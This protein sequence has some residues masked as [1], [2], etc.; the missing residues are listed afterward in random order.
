MTVEN[1][2]PP[3]NTNGD[4][5]TVTFGFNFKIQREAFLKVTQTIVAT[6]EETD[7]AIVSSTGIGDPAGGT[8]TVGAAPP[9]GS[10]VSVDSNVD[11]EQAV[12]LDG[13]DIYPPTVEEMIDAVVI[14]NQGQETKINRSIRV[15]VSDAVVP[16]LPA[17]AQRADKIL[18]FTADGSDFLMVEGAAASQA[19]VDQAETQADRAVA[20]ATYPYTS[21]EQKTGAFMPGT[22]ES[23]TLFTYNSVSDAAATLPALSGLAAGYNIGACRTAGSGDVTFTADDGALI[24]GQSSIVLG[25]DYL[26]LDFTINEA[27]DEWVAV[28]KAVVGVPIGTG[29]GDIVAIGSDGKLPEIDGSRLT[30]VKDS[31]A[32]DTALTAY[33]KAEIIAG[34]PGGTYGK[35]ISDNFLT[36][37]LAVST[38]ATYDADGDYYHNPGE[39]EEDGGHADSSYT[40]TGY[41]LVD[42]TWAVNNSETVTKVKIK[43][44]SAGAVKAKLLLENS[45]TDLDILYEETFSHSGG[46]WQTFTLTTPQDIPASG[47]YRIG[48]YSA[49]APGNV[50]AS[51]ARA[52]ISSDSNDATTFTADTGGIWQAG[53]FYQSD[54]LN[55]ILQSAAVTL[56]DADPSDI[57]AL[58]RVEDIDAV[59]D[60]TDR[61][62]SFSIDNGAT[63]STATITALGAYGVEDAMI[64]TE[65]D[66]SG[67]TGDQFVVKLVTANNKAQRIKQYVAIPEY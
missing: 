22:D 16:S 19:Y 11:F 13:N 42:R 40:F 52:Y 3:T 41:T 2:L 55:I 47:T 63:F 67:Q 7:L 53:V 8:V 21:G 4:G 32:R 45:S 10:I 25:S 12:E 37:T 18:G 50:G 27:G 49:G 65:A 59:V 38:N 15:P 14:Q 66:V 29:A 9:S 30:N 31:A 43:Q 54:P 36:D 26:C 64:K 61:M 28:D 5:T 46:G 23:L 20:A 56:E 1:Q 62:I 44:E 24:N 6:G 57:T 17:K 60:G 39:I 48:V 33:V 58:F 34:D 35:I 51:A